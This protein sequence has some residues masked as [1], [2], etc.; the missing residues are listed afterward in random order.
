MSLE[1]TE[2][3]ST[4]KS[5]NTLSLETTE[6]TSTSKSTNTLS[7]ETTESTSTS[8]STLYLCPWKL[9]KVQVLCTYVLPLLRYGLVL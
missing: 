7:L 1:T 2:S 5:T 9:Q 8:K 6:S 4:S 3:T